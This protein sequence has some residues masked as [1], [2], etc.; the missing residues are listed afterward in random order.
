MLPMSPMGTFAYLNPMRSGGG[1]KSPRPQFFCPHVFNFGAS[2][3]CF[4][5]FSNKIV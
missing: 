5:D 4:G 3:L 1:V 2:L